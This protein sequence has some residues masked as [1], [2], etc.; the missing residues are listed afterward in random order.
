M[1]ID[2]EYSVKIADSLNLTIG[3]GLFIDQSDAAED[4][5]VTMHDWTYIQLS[6]AM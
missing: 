3:E 2:L 4:K 1:E 5:E 6:L